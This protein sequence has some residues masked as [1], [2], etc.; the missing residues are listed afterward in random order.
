MQ[1]RQNALNEWLQIQLNQSSF[2]LTP[3]A[4]DASFRHYLRLS[5]NNATRIVMDAPPEKENIVPFIRVNQTLQSMGVRTPTIHAVDLKQGFILL[6]DLGDKLLLNT[7]TQ[8]NQDNLYH[9]ALNTL[10][11]I[12]KCPTESIPIFDKAHMLKEI[13][14]FHDWF[15]TAYLGLTLTPEEEQ[16][17]GTTFNALTDHLANQPQVF[18]HRDYHSR[19]LMVIEENAPSQLGVI[20]FQDAMYGPITYDLASLLKDCYI[21]LPQAAYNNYLEFFHQHQPLVQQWSIQ[22][23]MNEVDFCGLQRHLKV[24]G[25]FCRLALRD[26][27]P[28]YLGDLPLTMDYTIACLKRHPSFTPFLQFMEERV[29]PQFMEVSHA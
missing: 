13:S 29:L 24:L 26:N 9:S 20:D 15:L 21:K 23:M 11:H 22:T 5:S 25:I 12:Q 6:D 17:L 2:T 19:N 10:I 8:R 1:T 7:I 3:L 18:I 27:K 16:I 14:L 4:G 28:N